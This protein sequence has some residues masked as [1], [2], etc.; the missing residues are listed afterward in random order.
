MTL[1]S[2]APEPGNERL[3]GVI[4]LLADLARR[5]PWAKYTINDAWLISGKLKSVSKGTAAVI[6]ACF[7]ACYL[8]KAAVVLVLFVMVLADL[9]LAKAVS[10]APGTDR[11]G[12]AAPG[13]GAGS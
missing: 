2:D 1:S 13:T 4:G 8:V 9:A 3:S 7:V 6:V 5:F 12:G 11:R 10:P